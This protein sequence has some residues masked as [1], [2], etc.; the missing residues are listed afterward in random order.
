MRALITDDVHP[1]L[2]EQLQGLGY[3]VDFRPE[4]TAEKTASIIAP[5]TGL[6]INSKIFCGE[7]LLSQA[8]NLKWVG[9]LGSGMEVIDTK[10]CE[11]HGVKYFNSPEGNRNAVAEHALGLLLNILNNISISYNEVRQGQW[12]REPNRGEELSGKTVG[13]IAFGNTGEAF[14]KVL[15]GFDVRILAY[16]KYKKG[17]G[18]DRVKEASMKEIFAEADVVS[19]HLP[20]T[21]ETQQMIDEAFFGRFAKPIYL[22][23]TSRGKVVKTTALLH[24]VK[25]GHVKAA[26]LDV[27]ENEK[28]GKLSSPEQEW[29]DG[30]IAEKRILLT[31]HIAGW[32]HESKRKI[33]EVVIQR[34]KQLG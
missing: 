25:S 23:N 15:G 32:T 16:D 9:R 11:A 7:E 21:P 18:N 19:L 20:L 33:A 3:I 4:I 31:P 29:F 10:A 12:I 1:L 22:I 6:I 27:L 24:A 5:Y 14:S 13:I 2:I 17:F 8:P 26:A 30:L 28:I 34:I